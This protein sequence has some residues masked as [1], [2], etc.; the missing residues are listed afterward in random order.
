MHF[1]FQVAVPMVSTIPSNGT[2]LGSPSPRVKEKLPFA[3]SAAANGVPS[4]PI[5]EATIEPVGSFDACGYTQYVISPGIPLV[6]GLLGSR[7]LKVYVNVV[8]PVE[9]SVTPE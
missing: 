1:P 7:P 3:L 9:E 4:A 8:L 6:D 2:L 5:A